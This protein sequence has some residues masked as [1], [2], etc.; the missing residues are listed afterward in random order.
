MPPKDKELIEKQA[1]K[2]ISSGRNVIKR[3]L[4]GYIKRVNYLEGKEFYDGIIDNALSSAKV[5]IEELKRQ[6]KQEVMSFNKLVSDNKHQ[7]QN[8]RDDIFEEIKES[9]RKICSLLLQYGNKKIS[10]LKF[11]RL[12]MEVLNDSSRRRK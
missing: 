6:V 5:E 7:L 12:V 9:N 4:I 1:D 8:Q 2:I 10:W 3:E 11:Q